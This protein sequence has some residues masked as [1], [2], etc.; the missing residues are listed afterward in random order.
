MCLL[1]N[2]ASFDGLSRW[3]EKSNGRNNVKQNMAKYIKKKRKK[4]S[5]FKITFSVYESNGCVFSLRTHLKYQHFV[6]CFWLMFYYLK[7]NQA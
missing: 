5:I 2:G 3:K 7:I 6:V 4:N 1:L